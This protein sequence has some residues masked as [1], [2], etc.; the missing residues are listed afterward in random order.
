MIS[1][2]IARV[3]LSVVKVGPIPAMALDYIAVSAYRGHALGRST[4]AALLRHRFIVLKNGFYI[5]SK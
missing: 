4:I 1:I 2:H 3:L 5:Y